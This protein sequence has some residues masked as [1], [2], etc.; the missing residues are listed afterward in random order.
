MSEGFE[1][2][3]D[4]S[5]QDCEKY[6]RGEYK[7]WPMTI[8]WCCEACRLRELTHHREHHR[9]NRSLHWGALPGP[10]FLAEW[11]FAK[12]LVLRGKSSLFAQGP[13]KS[14]VEKFVECKLYFDTRQFGWQQIADISKNLYSCNLFLLPVSIDLPPI[15]DRASSL[16]HKS[17]HVHCKR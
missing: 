13:Q 1:H 4:K 7:R 3:Y 16:H 2:S 15:P 8:P 6:C 9:E 11:S 10:S 14:F 17:L 12:S 5:M